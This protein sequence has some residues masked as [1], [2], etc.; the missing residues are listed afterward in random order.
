MSP[1]ELRH[2][3]GEGVGVRRHLHILD[4]CHL[5][6]GVQAAA[7]RRPR[8]GDLRCERRRRGS[9]PDDKSSVPYSSN[10]PV[11]IGHTPERR[12][13]DVTHPEPEGGGGP[14]P[15]RS[16]ERRPLWPLR[17]ADQQ[18]LSSFIYTYLLSIIDIIN[19]RTY[20]TL[21]LYKSCYGP[22]KLVHMYNNMLINIKVA[23]KRIIFMY[24]CIP[25]SEWCCCCNRCE[26]L[27]KNLYLSCFINRKWNVWD[28]N[29]YIALWMV[30]LLIIIFQRMS[31]NQRKTQKCRLYMYLMNRFL[32]ESS[33]AEDQE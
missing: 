12:R 11:K 24:R 20:G 25:G 1:S 4:P 29:P 3:K 2:I 28:R 10:T 22:K 5:T 6:L 13:G 21:Y 33:M 7:E 15:H 19:R 27:M 23:T 9:L 8:N 26:M 31:R 17:M 32:G 30:A 14:P 16:G 18:Q